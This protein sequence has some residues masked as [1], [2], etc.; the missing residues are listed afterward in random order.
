[1]S[2]QE[3][4]EKSSAEK[5]EVAKNLHRQLTEKDKEIELLKVEIERDQQ[6]MITISRVIDHCPSLSSSFLSLYHR[7]HPLEYLLLRNS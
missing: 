6:V 4:L 5:N 2:E 3:R 1:M 7:N